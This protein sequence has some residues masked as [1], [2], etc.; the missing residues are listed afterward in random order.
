MATRTVTIASSV[1]LHAR[2]A[3][4]FV[5]AATESGLDVEIAKPGEDPTAPYP[6]GSPQ[7]KAVSGVAEQL[8]KALAGAKDDAPTL[9][10]LGLLLGYA[11]VFWLGAPGLRPALV[12][13]S[14]L[15]PRA[16]LT[17]VVDFGRSSHLMRRAG[18][19]ATALSTVV[20]ASLRSS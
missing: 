1:G 8:K 17:P 14:V 20:I 6:S 7:Q 5:E 3:A 11:W 19:S 18:R 12:G 2:P 13:W 9:A 16:A 15:Y 4:L 10:T